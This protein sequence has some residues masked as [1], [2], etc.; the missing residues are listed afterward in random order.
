MGHEEEGKCGFMGTKKEELGVIQEEEKII[1]G[2]DLKRHMGRSEEVIERAHG[3]REDGEKIKEIR[4]GDDCA[5]LFS[6]A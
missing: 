1:G 3:C 5:I 2:K 4:K 6:N